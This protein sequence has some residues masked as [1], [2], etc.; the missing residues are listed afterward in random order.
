MLSKKQSKLGLK[1][2]FA[3]MIAEFDADGDGILVGFGNIIYIL[4]FE[5]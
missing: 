2:E 1:D 5:V 4:K 3:A